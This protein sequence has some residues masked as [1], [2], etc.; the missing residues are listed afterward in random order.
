MGAV[1]WHFSAQ[2]RPQISIKKEGITMKT[3][4]QKLTMA[5]AAISIMFII[6]GVITLLPGC[7][8][9]SASDSEA[10]PKQ[11]DSQK[12]P[13]NTLSESGAWG[14]EA[15]F[16][17]ITDLSN[18]TGELMVND[19]V[20]GQL[21]LSYEREYA[22]AVYVHNTSNEPQQDVSITLHYPDILRPDAEDNKLNVLLG[23]GGKNGEDG[24]I[25]GDDLELQTTTDLT[26]WPADSNGDTSVAIIRHADGTLSELPLID[27]GLHGAKQASTTTYM[28]T[29]DKI[30]GGESFIMF[31]VL[32]ALP[33]DV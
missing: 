30:E 14:D 25:I 18:K 12:S 1:F 29:M 5:R 31:F 21:A 20:S 17:R 8:K 9:S 13:F 2:N 10:Q 16:L 15:D 19:F 27:L 28:A 4:I 7:Q 3:V 6:L 23:W 32:E 33:T 11:S 26:L 22:V 24:G